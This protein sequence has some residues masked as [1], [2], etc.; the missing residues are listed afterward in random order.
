MVNG[1]CL[2]RYVKCVSE[3]FGVVIKRMNMRRFNR[4]DSF[5]ESKFR[6]SPNGYKGYKVHKGYKVYTHVSAWMCV[7]CKCVRYMCCVLYCAIMYCAALCCAV[8][9]YSL[10]C[11]GI[12][13]Y[14]VVCCSVFCCAVM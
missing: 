12:L 8:L 1:N 2:Q 11:C 9:W 5:V 3:E 6:L 10:V 7:L 14:A 13:W 4:I